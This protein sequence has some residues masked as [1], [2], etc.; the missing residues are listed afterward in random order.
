MFH[1]LAHNVRLLCLRGIQPYR[2]RRV[3][4]VTPFR[5][6]CSCNIRA[7]GTRVLKELRAVDFVHRLIERGKLAKDHY[8]D[9]RIHIIEASEQ[10][11][12]LGASSKLNAERVFLDHLHDLGRATA[13]EWLARNFDDIGH[14]S[15]VN[16]RAMFQGSRGEAS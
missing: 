15:T 7:S 14:V 2:G 13:A 9:V 10:M 4:A 6:T 11:S 3:T 8:T 1:F 12:A 5:A 16:V